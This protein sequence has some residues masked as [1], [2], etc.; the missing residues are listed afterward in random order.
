MRFAVIEFRL[1][2]FL[3]Y[4]LANCFR[5]KSEIAFLLDVRLKDMSN[6]EKTDARKFPQMCAFIT[7]TCLLSHFDLD[8]LL[9]KW[10]CRIAALL[11]FIS[12]CA[13]SQSIRIYFDTLKVEMFDVFDS[14]EIKGLCCRLSFNSIGCQSHRTW[15]GIHCVRCVVDDRRERDFDVRRKRN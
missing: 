12:F 10:N 7:D 1:N 14:N 3:K 13:A 6:D 9:I 15:I 2:S 5:H 4:Y 11:W 8:R